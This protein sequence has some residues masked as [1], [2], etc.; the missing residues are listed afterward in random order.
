MIGSNGF[1][2]FILEEEKRE[3]VNHQNEH[4]R[5]KTSFTSHTTSEI[6]NGKGYNQRSHLAESFHH[7]MSGK[8]QFNFMA[9]T[10]KSYLKKGD[11]YRTQ[12]QH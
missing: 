6:W 11:Q 5:L 8:H 9:P 2:A 7:R 1:Y 3:Q 12:N 10:D 4:N